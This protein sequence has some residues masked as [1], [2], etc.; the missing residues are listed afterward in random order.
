MQRQQGGANGPRGQHPACGQGALAR[1][2]PSVTLN[3]TRPRVQHNIAECGAVAAAA[4]ECTRLTRHSTKCQSPPPPPQNAG[5][6]HRGVC[7][8]AAAAAGGHVAEPGAQLCSAAQRAAGGDPARGAR[9]TTLWHCALLC[10]NHAARRTSAL[11]K[12]CSRCAPRCAALRRTLGCLLVHSCAVLFL[13]GTLH[14][15]LQLQRCR[16][17]WCRGQQGVGRAQ[18]RAL[19]C[20]G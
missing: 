11:W 6:R 1:N 15:G 12:P 3:K 9:C 14:C 5:G 8:A 20:F 13:C 10:F 16:V 17:C 4:R 18:C 19:S 2:M 7:G